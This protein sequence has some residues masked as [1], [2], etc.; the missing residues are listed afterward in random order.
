MDF[1]FAK[2]AAATL[3]IGVAMLVALAALR[4]RGRVRLWQRFADLPLW[5][6][7][8]P[9]ASAWRPLLRTGIVGGAMAALVVALMDPRWGLRIEEIPRRGLECYFLVDVSRSMLAEDATPNRL[10]RARQFVSDALDRAAGD[11]VGLI[12]FAGVAAIRVPLTLNYGAFRSVLAELSPQ[13]A[14]RGGTSL[15]EAI[16]LAVESFPEDS[17]AGR[18]IVILSDGEDMGDD[19]VEAAREAQAKGIR[20][21]TVGIGDANEGARIPINRAGARAWVMHDGQEVWSRMNPELL[22]TV[23]DAGGG[24]FIRA[25]TAQADFGSIYDETVGRLERGEFEGGTV[26]RRTQRYMW[27]VGLALALLIIESLISDRR[28]GGWR[29]RRSQALGGGLA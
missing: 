11:R 7:L 9:A 22:K 5:R 19:P 17:G 13:S 28:D 10:E 2:P 29:T 27:F 18:A 20:V 16:H 4:Q 3:L 26:E 12:E 24:V 14:G 25:G 1:E 23:A 15:A 21:F 8:A 6:R